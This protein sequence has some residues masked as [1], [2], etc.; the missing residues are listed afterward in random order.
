M[1]QEVQK[2]KI[3]TCW[4][5]G[6][7]GC[8]MS[9]LD[10]DEAIVDVLAKA[11][12]VFGPLVDAQ[13]WPEGVDVAIIEGAVSSQDDLDLVT[14]AR[15]RSGIV[16]ALG[17]CAVTGNVSTMRNN[18]PTRALLERIYVEGVDA[19]PQVPTDGVPPLLKH[20][21]PLQAHIKV[22]V[23]V[24]GCPPTAETILYVIGELLEGRVPD[25]GSRQRFG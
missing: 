1:E 8:H 13:E 4:L 9:L 21:Q 3:G 7:S 19:Q 16:V 20:A 10:M 12:I 22:D 18:I 5:D 2:A 23:H 24:P 11:D 6:C 14:E 15:E 17:D 25:V